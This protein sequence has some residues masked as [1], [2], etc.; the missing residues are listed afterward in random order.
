MNFINVEVFWLIPII[1]LFMILL[2][3][4]ARVRRENILKTLL[5]ARYTESAHVMV[6]KGR[7]TFRFLLLITIVVLLAAAVARPWWGMRLV[8]YETK[9]RDLMV[10]FDVSKSMLAQDIQPSRLEHAKWFL[11]QL[12]D[13]TGGDRFGLVAFS[14]DAFLE[15]PMT[16]DKTSFFQYIDELNTSSIPLGGTNLQLALEKAMKAFQAAEGRNRAIIL[17]TDGD[18]LTGNSSKAINE[19]KKLNIPLFI[20]GIGDPATPALIPE[21][22]SADKSPHFKRDAQGKLVK[23]KLNEK[24]M[25]KL[26]QATNG[27]YVRSTVTNPGLAQI[28]QH[29]KNLVP[30]NLE[31]G[32]KTRPIERF[33]YFLAAAAIL[34]G[35]WMALS[36]RLPKSKVHASNSL[37]ALLAFICLTGS[38]SANAQK[39]QAPPSAVKPSDAKS[40]TDKKQKAEKPNPV[41]TYNQGREIH[42]K[43]PQEAVSQYEKAINLAEKSPAVR[44]RAFQNLG[45][46]EHNKARTGIAKSM[47]MVKQQQLDGALKQ[48]DQASQ[49]LNQT[50][51]MYVKSMSVKVPS[52]VNKK[53]DEQQKQKVAKAKNTVAVNQQF[54][55]RDREIIKKLKKM[56]EELKKRQKQAQKKTQQ[57]Q[58]QQ[59]KKNK[60]QQ[61]KQQQQKKQQ[62]KQ[63]QQKKQQQ[64]QQQQKQQQDQTQ[65]SLKD[66]QNAVDKLKEQAQ[67]LQQKKMEQNAAKAREEL[68]KAEQAQ[69]K[70][71]GKK[72]EEHIKRALKYLGT[73]G[74]QGKDKK[75]QQ[76]KQGGGKQQQ[77]KQQPKPDKG[78]KKDQKRQQ[79]PQQARAAQAE[80]QPKDIDKK[81][82]RALLKMMAG[83]EKNLRKALKERQRQM[84]GETKVEKDW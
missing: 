77:K 44:A 38:T 39:L 26:A 66:A 52:Q 8:P 6:S 56:I 45:V 81:Q 83:K 71:Q 24:Q 20:V 55:L 42:N 27:I 79:Q 70:D 28:E 36:E 29:I 60:Q 49:I 67:K 9:G 59:Q 64:K 76:K 16:S 82:A 4:R 25:I 43:K 40:V 73:D 11:R 19:L 34:T 46:I 80:Q 18:E 7:R 74:K 35:L 22:N 30:E 37:I 72:A 69:K 41:K 10:L 68:N 57:A 2:F 33:Y 75:Q 50:E 32:I 84:Y 58:K 21:K 54:L 31:K 78:Q 48:L 15:C 51:E 23:T 17:I 14:G 47:A 63:Q 65:K 62:Q 53:V 61:Q 12:V 13:E 5:G 1:V 3:W